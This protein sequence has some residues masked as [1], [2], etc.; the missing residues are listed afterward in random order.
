MKIEKL[1]RDIVGRYDLSELP[2]KINEIIDVLN[3]SFITDDPD[4][5]Y[6]KTVTVDEVLNGSIVLTDLTCDNIVPLDNER[7]LNN[8]VDAAHEITSDGFDIKVSEVF[9]NM[10][11]EIEPNPLTNKK[12]PHCG[13]SYYTELYSTTTAVY[14]PP[15]YKDGVNINPDMNK[16]T[17]HCRCL[18]CHKEFTV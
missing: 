7:I 6:G 3:N 8:K 14:Y 17:T 18:N 1:K 16:S 5:I 15:I 4:T 12:C 2:D 11:A 13:K 9:D 10:I